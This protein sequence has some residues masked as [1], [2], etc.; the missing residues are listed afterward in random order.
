MTG[1]G[2]LQPLTVIASAAKRSR[3][4]ETK[5]WISLGS[6]HDHP[7]ADMNAIIEVDHVFIA[8]PDAA[9]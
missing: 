4:R 7:R 5:S 1:L 9:G 3:S 2:F 8:H 6:D